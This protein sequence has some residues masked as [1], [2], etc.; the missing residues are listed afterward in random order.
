MIPA[1]WFKGGHPERFAA[2]LLLIAYMISV[3]SAP[4]RVAGV[5]VG[6]AA[7]DFVLTLIFGHMALNGNRWWPVAMTAVL[8]LTLMVHVAV[9]LAPELDHRADI[10]ARIGLGVLTVSCLFAG[11]FERW[12]AGERPASETI[13]ALGRVSAP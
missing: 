11:V 9:G 6:D 10:S 13:R 12:L 7:A 5:I 8:V 2:G 4:Y 3:L 1:A